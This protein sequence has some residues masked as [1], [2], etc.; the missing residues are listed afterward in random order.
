MVFPSIDR[1]ASLLN[2]SSDAAAP[3]SQ[4]SPFPPP[5]PFFHRRSLGRTP[6]LA[7]CI[8]SSN[9]ASPPLPLLYTLIQ[10]PPYTY[11]AHIPPLPMGGEG[12]NDGWG[13]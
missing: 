1:R 10:Y 9:D 4:P 3:R 5:P 8:F 6:F 13:A 2:P 12:E 11:D 7:M